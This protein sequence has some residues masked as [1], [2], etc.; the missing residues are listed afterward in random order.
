MSLDPDGNITHLRFT[1]LSTSDSINREAF[2]F[3]KKQ[4][5]KPTEVNGERVSTCSTE[6]IIIDF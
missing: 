6:D 3:L 5:F 1:R 4:H 2:E